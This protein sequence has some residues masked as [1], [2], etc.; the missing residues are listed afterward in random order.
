MVIC[1]VPPMTD[2]WE[3]TCILGESL[4]SFNL[5]RGRILGLVLFAIHSHFYRFG[6]RF[7]I[8][9]THATSYSFYSSVTVHC[10]EKGGYLIENHIPKGA[11]LKKSI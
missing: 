6:L 10:K 3:N 7:I 9:Q 11:W 4:R 5:I 2:M 1:N 8:F